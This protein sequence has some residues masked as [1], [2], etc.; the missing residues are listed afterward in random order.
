VGPGLEL[1]VDGTLASVHRPG[2][3]LT[4]I[5]WWTLA[6]PLLLLPPRAAGRRVLL[7]GLAA[8]SV[9]QA[10]RALDPG[11]PLVGV[12][13][14]D[15]VLRAGR[16]HFGL[17]GLG[18]EIVRDDALAYLRRERRLFDLVVEDLFVGP[19]R[20]VRK[21]E[22]LVGEGYPLIGR[23]LRPGG[24][25]VANTIHET[26]EIVGAAHA[27]AGRVT[28]LDVRDY[29]NTIVVAGRELP[30]PRSIRTAM[31]ERAELRGLLPRLEIRARR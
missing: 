15:E 12:E 29:H 21:P 6:A 1:R 28:T 4:G 23:R 9:A 2:R 10:L 3:G 24:L 26:A 22:W 13:Y 25:L 27:A 8:G 31:A 30:S 16:E 17:D 19:S 7:L 18:V 20:S 11:A 5:V 14:D